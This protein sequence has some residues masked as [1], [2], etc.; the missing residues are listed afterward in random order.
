[1]DFGGGLVLVE[2]RIRPTYWVRL[3]LL[4]IGA[5]EN[6]SSRAGHRSFA[7]VRPVAR[8]GAAARQGASAASAAVRLLAPI[9]APDD[10]RVVPGTRSR[11]ASFQVAVPVVALS[12][13]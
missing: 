13:R 1:V 3:P 4:A 11:S 12:D 9:R 7:G 2:R 6:K 8:P 5:V 10:D